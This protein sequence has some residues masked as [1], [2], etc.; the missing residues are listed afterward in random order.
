MAS[1]HLKKQLDE[2]GQLDALLNSQSG[3]T[4]L[5]EKSVF[6]MIDIL[7]KLKRDNSRIMSEMDCFYD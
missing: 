2:V 5:N 1:T 6:A 7:I 4:K 3:I